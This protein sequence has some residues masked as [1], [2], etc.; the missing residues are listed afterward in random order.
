MSIFCKYNCGGSEVPMIFVS[1]LDYHRSHPFI[2]HSVLVWFH[3]EIYQ[4]WV[5]VCHVWVSMSES[6]FRSRISSSLRNWSSFYFLGC[7]TDSG[8]TCDFSGSL[9]NNYS[10]NK[11]S[12]H[13]LWPVLVIVYQKVNLIQTIQNNINW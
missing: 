4:T 11:F 10:L 1:I 9:F 12:V 5:W 2:D 8:V 3:V 7:K 13:M 6:T